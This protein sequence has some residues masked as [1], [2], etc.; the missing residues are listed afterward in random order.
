MH[1]EF[2]KHLIKEKTK[3]KVYDQK[4]SVKKEMHQVLMHLFL[5]LLSSLIG[6]IFQ[7]GAEIVILLLEGFV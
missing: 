6:D 4:E 1:I 2:L 3:N 7:D 5:F